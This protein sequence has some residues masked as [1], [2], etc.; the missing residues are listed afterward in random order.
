MQAVLDAWHSGKLKSRPLLLISNNRKAEALSRARE[1]GLATQVINATTHPE[2]AD[3]DGAILATL[4][5]HRIDLIL[6]AGYRNA[7]ARR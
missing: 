5:R 3:L 1:A 7:S 6:L 4:Q 2:P